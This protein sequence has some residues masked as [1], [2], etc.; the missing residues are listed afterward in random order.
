MTNSIKYLLSRDGSEC[1][2]SGIVEYISS[3]FLGVLTFFENNVIAQD[4]EKSVKRDVLLSLG[5]IIRLLGSK[6]ITQFRF[7]IV[8]LLRTAVAVKEIDLHGI[9]AQV[10]DIFLRTVDVP[11]LGSLLSTIVVSMEPLLKEHSREVNAILRYLIISNGNLLGSHLKDLFFI[12]SL[13]VVGDVKQVIVQQNNANRKDVDKFDRL[14]FNYSNQVNH[15]NLAVRI[16]G[17]NYLTDLFKKSRS[18]INRLIMGQPVV[19][20][21]ME[22][23]LNL[24]IMSCKHDEENLQLA[25][26]I[27]LGEIGAIEPRYLRENYAPQKKFCSS[28]LSTDFAISILA[29]LCHAYQFQKDSKYVDSFSLAIQ[30]ILQYHCVDPRRE[31]QMDIWVAI[32]ERMRQIMEP[33]LTSC[34]TTISVKNSYDRHPVFPCRTCTDWAYIWA[35]NIIESIENADVKRLLGSFKPSLKNDGEIMTT[36]MPY[37]ILHGL[38]YSPEER[39]EKIRE[40]FDLIFKIAAT[41]ESQSQLQIEDRKE[42]PIFGFLPSDQFEGNDQDKTEDVMKKC[43]KLAFNLL[44]FIGNWCQNY[45]QQNYKDLSSVDYKIVNK[46]YKSFDKKTLAVANFNCGEHARALQFMEDV[47]MTTPSQLQSELSFLGQIYAE[48]LDS[49]SLEGAMGL[50]TIN[51]TLAEQILLNNVSG[52]LNES[53]ACYERMIQEKEL[54]VYDMKDMVQCY[55]SLDQPETALLICE[56]LM[57]KLYDK[58][59]KDIPTEISAEPLWRL[60]RFEDVEKTVNAFQLHENVNWGVRCGQVLNCVRQNNIEQFTKQTQKAR[61]VI[62]KS[63]RM[64]G[65]GENSYT[66][67]YDQVLKLHL[68]TEIEKTF[69]LFE[70][71]YKNNY[72]LAPKQL[73]VYFGEMRE[74]LELFRNQKNIQTILCLR[75]ILFRE[76]HGLL[77]KNCPYKDTLAR[78]S[79]TIDGEVGKSWI[80]STRVARKSGAVQQANLY[81]LNCEGYKM[82]DLFLEKAKLMWEK[83][84]QTNAF[85][86]LNRGMEQLLQDCKET[87]FNNLPQEEKR[88]FAKA[89]F[90]LATYNAESMNIQSDL[91][92]QYFNDS[93]AANKESEICFVHYAQFLDKIYESVPV[94]RKS[95]RFELLRDIMTNYG[96]S[97]LYG[98]KFIYQSMP[99][100]LSIW[101]DFTADKFSDS[102][103]GAHLTKIADGFSDKLPAFMY[104]TAFSQLVS[105]IC[106]PSQDVYNVIKTILV[107][108]VLSFPQQSLWMLLCVLKSS[109][110]S[111]EKRCAMVLG[112]RRLN[113]SGMS[114]L[115]NDFNSLAV[116]LIDLT[117]ADIKKGVSSTTVSA[118][119]RDLPRIISDHSFSPIIIPCEKFMQPI[120]PSPLDKNKPVDAYVPF[121]QSMAYIQGI[122]EQVRVLQS[123]QKPRRVNFKAS[124]GLAYSFLLKPKDDLRRDFRLM[125]FNNIVKHYLNMDLEARERRLNIRTYGVLPLNEEYGIIEWLDNLQTFRQI[126]LLLYRQNKSG[127]SGTDLQ[128]YFNDGPL[129]LHKAKERFHNVFLK[130]HPPVFDQWFKMNFTTSHNWYMARTAY[131]RTCGVMSIVGYVLGLGDRHCENI[132][133][134]VTNGD[135]VHVD[136]NC[137]F[138]AGEKFTIPERVPFRLTHNMVHAMGPLGVEGP[139]RKSCEVTLRLM[140]ARQQTLM[141]ILRPFIYDPLVTWKKSVQND[142]SSERTDSDA[143]N[144]VQNIENRLKG[145]VKI[146]NKMSNIPL[147]TEG[148]VN[149]VIKEAMDINN[150]APM[151]LGWSPFM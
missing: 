93:L 34:Y 53:A 142:G 116:R 48:L 88:V 51:L 99:R 25:A 89:K 63:L 2:L 150:L 5:E 60:G 106:H 130:R 144:N 115:I 16:Y 114:K 44:D 4:N 42:I 127:M 111:R 118:L 69:G 64:T 70:D 149:F 24:L 10:W 21:Q 65:I 120:L 123:L 56:G 122:D 85:Q 140:R 31:Q 83:G 1:S 55:L 54:G 66:K 82:K 13:D 68:I 128:P 117:K 77:A 92:V 27:C 29:A 57:E 126:L 49:D 100:L 20:D 75:R 96:N 124:D 76:L 107:K 3:K 73:D 125:E 43:A 133:F 108:L 95:E 148:Q 37:I 104:F 139:F 26:G 74:R 143:M 40:E 45:K 119:V 39:R 12:E 136:F 78:L 131:V 22:G 50:K 151:Y 28:I 8:S 23:T 9:C 94:T 109:Y 146:D 113:V 147:S 137:L 38:Q 90:L 129:P 84:D 138:N 11:C 97:M 35:S 61:E 6:H 112:D 72:E 41:K 46:F 30:E 134:D 47:V 98:F 36:L 86:T 102:K 18:K 135:N 141:S 103:L 58:H 132:L 91:N 87:N 81:I 67:G 110:S 101:L 7:K 71:M 79:L 17:I 14:F 15:D 52:K 121:P 145:F 62:L 59:A 19:D 80:T 105:R 32:P 33:L